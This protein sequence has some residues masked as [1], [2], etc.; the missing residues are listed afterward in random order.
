MVVSC[1]FLVLHCANADKIR[2][3]L[4]RLCRSYTGPSLLAAAIHKVY[5]LL[6]WSSPGKAS[7]RSDSSGSHRKRTFLLSHLQVWANHNL[8]AA[9]TLCKLFCL[10]RY[11][12]KSSSEHP[13]CC[14][15]A[16]LMFCPSCFSRKWLEVMLTGL[17]IILYSDVIHSVV[18]LRLHVRTPSYI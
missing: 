18:A 7:I 12:G 14:C 4:C 15:L 2:A 13:G 11:L 1:V 8:L 17:S 3:A 6:I 10:N 5:L 16:L 9:T